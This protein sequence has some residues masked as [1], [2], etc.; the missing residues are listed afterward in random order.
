MGATHLAN[1]CEA[2]ELACREGREADV[3]VSVPRLLRA[4][5]LVIVF[6]E[7]FCKDAVA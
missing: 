2:L 6:V 5:G 4:A 7:E 1:I 3:N